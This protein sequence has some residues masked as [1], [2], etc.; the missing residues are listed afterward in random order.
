MRSAWKY[1]DLKPRVYYARGPDQYYASRYIQ[2]IFNILIDSLPITN[3]Y[4]RFYHAGIRIEADDTLF[5]YDYSSFTSRLDEV[6]CFL[7]ELAV[8]CRG[9]SVILLD[10]HHGLQ[11]KDLEEMITEYVDECNDFPL[12]DIQRWPEESVQDDTLRMHTTGMLGVPGNITSCTLLH[13]IHLAIILES[14]LKGKCVGDDAVGAKLVKSLDALEREVCG[15]GEVSMSKGATW[16]HDEGTMVDRSWNYVKRPI[17]RIEG[18]VAV[19]ELLTFPTIPGFFNLS[20][21]GIHTH[22]P[23]TAEALGRKQANALWS[24][25]RSVDRLGRDL[26]EEEEDLIDR[27]VYVFG[28][29][30]VHTLEPPYSRPAF[31]YP[32]RFE[33]GLWKKSLTIDL[34]DRPV[35]LPKGDI[36]DFENPEI[37]WE[38]EDE[39]RSNKYVKLA[40]HLGWAMVK[41]LYETV[42]PRLCPER[43]DAWLNGDLRP[44]YLLFVKRSCPRYLLDLMNDRSNFSVPQLAVLYD[45]EIED[46]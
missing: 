21:G 31:V 2:E 32:R 10:T 1:T 17:D 33:Q 9:R 29:M 41:D 42:I 3:R 43:F 11:I 38:I 28:K 23:M 16:D 30:A 15:L 39:V 12:F 7:R 8:F 18:R 5:I 6:K 27:F 14:L 44:H 45:V 25:C 24:L 40:S 22:I 4:L 13:G 20:D 36:G 34:W 26:T 37:Y 46:H 19:G 35:L